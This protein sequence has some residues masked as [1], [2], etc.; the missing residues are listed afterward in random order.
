MAARLVTKSVIVFSSKILDSQVPWPSPACLI[1][2]GIASKHV[3]FATWNTI[4][5]VDDIILRASR[6]QDEGSVEVEVVVFNLIV[7]GQA[8]E[9]FYLGRVLAVAEGRGEIVAT[10]QDWSQHCVSMPINEAMRNQKYVRQFYVRG[11]GETSDLSPGSLL[12]C[13]NGI[14]GWRKEHQPRKE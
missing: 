11:S 10:D 9:F 6:S 7:V 2:H 12:R 13:S 1:L 8:R 14:G 3:I 4:D 5:A